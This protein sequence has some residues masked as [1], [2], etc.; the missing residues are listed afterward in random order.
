LLSGALAAVA[1]SGYIVRGNQ[2]RELAMAKGQKRSTRE[3]KKPKQNKSQ[4]KGAAS[5]AAKSSKQ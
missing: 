4:K 3:P 2:P 1:R 5:G